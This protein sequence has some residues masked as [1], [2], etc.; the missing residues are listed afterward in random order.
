M[1]NARSM[2]VY[3]V[4]QNIGTCHG[5][6]CDVVWCYT[7]PRKKRIPME[8]G[9]IPLSRFEAPTPTH[10]QIELHDAA[11]VHFATCPHATRFRKR[12]A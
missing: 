7:Y 3:A 10:N 2:A 6:G 4:S 11:K 5:C 9:S 8:V 1:A 12:R